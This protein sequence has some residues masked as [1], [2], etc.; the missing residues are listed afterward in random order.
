VGQ[1]KTTGIDANAN[2]FA[3]FPQRCRDR[4]LA[5]FDLAADQVPLARESDAGRP[6][7]PY[8]QNLA[9]HVEK[10]ERRPVRSDPGVH[11]ARRHGLG[12]APRRDLRNAGRSRA[13]VGM[14][15]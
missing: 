14:T 6:I 7:A 12:A 8:H 10:D 11:L 3:G 5:G 15:L 2:F 9:A 13:A 1:P 4:R